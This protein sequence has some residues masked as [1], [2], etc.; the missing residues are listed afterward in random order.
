MV[1]RDITE[2]DLEK[3]LIQAQQ[4]TRADA[5]ASDDLDSESALVLVEQLLLDAR[6]KNRTLWLRSEYGE[7]ALDQ[8]RSDWFFGSP[9]KGRPSIKTGDLVVICAQTLTATPS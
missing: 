1:S 5:S 9:A 8:W 2:K 6:D 7:P 4:L 3:L